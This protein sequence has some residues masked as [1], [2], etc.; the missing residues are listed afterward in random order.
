MEPLHILL[1]EDNEGDILL[2]KEELDNS[3]LL[4]TFTVVKDGKEAIDFLTQ[5]EGCS[6]ETPPDLV[7]LDINLPKRN[8]QF[9]LKF[10]KENKFLNHIPVVMLTTS[11]SAIDREQAYKNL[12]NGFIIKPLEAP[13]FINMITTIPN[14]R[15]PFK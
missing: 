12:V 7:L 5:C 15:I 13:G 9:V 10:I 3:K 14:F 2:T 4:T 6:Q 8:G 1:V 11:S